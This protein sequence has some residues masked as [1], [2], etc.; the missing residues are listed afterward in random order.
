MYRV[1]QTSIH[2]YCMY[3]CTVCIRQLFIWVRLMFLIP[4]HKTAF[5]IILSCDKLVATQSMKVCHFTNVWSMCVWYFSSAS[6][7]MG[8]DLRTVIKLAL[9]K[10]LSKCICVQWWRTIFCT[11]T[12]TISESSWHQT[13]EAH[14]V[15]QNGAKSVWS[16]ILIFV[17]HSHFT[18][19]IPIK[20]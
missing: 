1:H 14:D 18:R 16:R 6:G 13:T 20:K 15:I 2:F 9:D 3:I 19:Y 8:Q 17:C 12:A 5:S 10:I 11:T 4:M 7:F